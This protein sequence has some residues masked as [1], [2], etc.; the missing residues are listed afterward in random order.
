ML[1]RQPTKITLVQD[2]IAAYDANKL[3]K[4]QEKIQ[5]QRQEST[6]FGDPRFDPSRGPRK[7]TRTKE[8]R[9]GLLSRN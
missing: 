5:E 4:D 6:S 3:K 9:L 1:R 8:Q 7:D 2:D